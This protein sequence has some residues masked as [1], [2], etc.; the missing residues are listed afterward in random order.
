MP[1]VPAGSTV[2]VTGAAGFVGGWVVT[3]LLRSVGYQGN[4]PLG[5]GHLGVVIGG[6]SSVITFDADGSAGPGAARPLVELLGVVSI[7]DL[8]ALFEVLVA[9]V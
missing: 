6:S 4:D 9:P 5:A 7:P 2:A 8:G 1:A 3:Q